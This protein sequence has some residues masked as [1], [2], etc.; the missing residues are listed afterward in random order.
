VPRSWDLLWSKLRHGLSWWLSAVTFIV[1][2]IGG[3]A[4]LVPQFTSNRTLVELV[5]AGALAAIASA[6]LGTL[7]Y[8]EVVFAR[9]DRWA[10]TLD[11]QQAAF[12]RLRDLSSVLGNALAA[13]YRHEPVTRDTLHQARYLV[14][15]VLDEFANIFSLMT[16]T[17]C[18]ACIKMIAERDGVMYVFA[19]A[20]DRLSAAETKKDDQKREA[21]LLDRLESN[22]DFLSLFDPGSPDPGYYFSADLTREDKYHSSSTNY[23]Q[24]VRG[25]PNEPARKDWFL[26]YRST[27]VFPIRQ[28]AQEHMGITEEKCVGFLAFDSASRRAFVRR[29]D[30]PL[31]KALAHAMY[32]PLAMYADLDQLLRAAEDEHDA[33]RQASV[34]R[35]GVR[36]V[37]PHHQA[38]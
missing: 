26:P 21:E 36:G 5:Q 10:G 14:E 22:T 16:T 25:N 12:E 20:R 31:G 18:R 27:I 32:T 23:W 17:R 13:H 28:E 4:A 38:S 29:W 15:E 6:A 11:R 30:V 35:Q 1:G 3:I 24:N 7:A 2:L 37:H 34:D 8:R 9:R 19:L 33:R